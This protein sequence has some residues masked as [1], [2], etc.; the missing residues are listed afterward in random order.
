MQ[1]FQGADLT[2]KSI[3]QSI[4]SKTQAIKRFKE[5]RGRAIV[6]GRGET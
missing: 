4:N 3:K 6:I 5:T 2:I 1:G